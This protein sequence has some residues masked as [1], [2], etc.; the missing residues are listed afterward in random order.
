MNNHTIEFNNYKFI[1]PANKS[2]VVF[3]TPRTGSTALCDILTKKTNLPFL[4]EMFNGTEI[5]RITCPAL[6]KIF[7]NHIIPEDQK[8][9]LTDS[10]V[11]GLRRK[12]LIAQVISYY[13]TTIS[14]QFSKLHTDTYS[15]N[16]TIPFDTI[17]EKK[18]V[19]G[20]LK[21]L[22]KLTNDYNSYKLLF[23]IELTY[24]DLAINLNESDF[25]A[26][27]KSNNYDVVYNYLA[28]LI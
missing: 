26:Q 27:E 7:P 24:E 28:K 17:E 21:I 3:A 23:S 12:D 9:L 16:V 14:N 15:S 4:S 1:I 2:I 10:F 25:V 8:Y 22:T 19:E 13:T 6:I 11:I 5:D 20:Y 18:L